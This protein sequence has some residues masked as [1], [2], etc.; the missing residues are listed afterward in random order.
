MNEIETK[1]ENLYSVF[2]QRLREIREELK[3]KYD[4]LIEEE[5]KHIEK[6]LKEYEETLMRKAELERKQMIDRKTSQITSE[7]RKEKLLYKKK[8][9]SRVFSSL[10]ERLLNLPIE[11]KKILYRKLYNDALRL[12]ESEDFVIV[13]NPEDAEIVS[14]IAGDKRVETSSEVTGGILLKK[15]RTI[16]RS[17]VDTF[18]EE[19][20]SEIFTFITK[21]AGEI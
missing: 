13:C 19:R 15:D 3:E 7:L 10:R 1:L 11:E 6:E 8:L 20:K 5:K 21:K 9:I 4:R 18:L 12:I 14:E 16:V 2:E 17:T